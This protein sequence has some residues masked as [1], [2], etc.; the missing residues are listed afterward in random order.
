MGEFQ[1]RVQ[2]AGEVAPLSWPEAKL[3]LFAPSLE[4][5]LSGRSQPFGLTR[6]ADTRKWNIT[7]FLSCIKCGTAHGARA[8]RRFWTAQTKCVSPQ[9]VHGPMLNDCSKNSARCSLIPS[10]VCTCENVVVVCSNISAVGDHDFLDMFGF[11]GLSY[12]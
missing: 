11:S 9:T 3:R 7:I 6:P 2:L 8:A 4:M 10:E 5:G 1:K 12:V